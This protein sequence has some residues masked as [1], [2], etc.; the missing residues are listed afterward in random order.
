MTKGNIF[1]NDLL[2]LIFN[3]TAIAD[4]AENDG[5]APATVL[6]VSLHTADPSE[7]GDQSTSEATYTG[8]ARVPV[9]RSSGGW[10]VSENVVSNTTVIPFPACTAVPN[11]ITYFGVGVAHSGAGKL[12]YS[13]ELDDPLVISLGMIPTFPIGD[14]DIGED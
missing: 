1:E 11:T 9:A 12:L 7:G 6:E 14:L 4:L 8:Y 3:G 5:S 10:T 2:K 13:G